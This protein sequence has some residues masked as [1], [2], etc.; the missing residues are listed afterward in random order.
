[1]ICQ[2]CGVE[3]PT[4]Y[5]SFHQNIG[6][7]VVRFSKSVEGRLCKRCVHKY[8][9]SLTGTTFFLGWW[10][11]ISFLV[12]PFFLLNNMVRYTTC[13]TM[14][15]VPEGAEP[16]VLTDEAVERIRP[17]AQRLFDGLN[18]GR[19]LEDVANEIAELSGA[20]LAQVVLFVR[21]AVQAQQQ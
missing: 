11:T 15:A 5:V 7:L 18:D 10:G 14:P 6:A 16:P 2:A 8:F 3:A 21:A 19:K 20:S 9:W 12:T 4:K 1:M 17:H 13:L